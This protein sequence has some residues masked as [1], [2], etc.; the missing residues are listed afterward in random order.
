MDVANFYIGLFKD[1]DDPMTRS[2]L[3]KFLY[4]AQAE[5]MVRLDYLLFE[6]E[7]EARDSGPVI[8][9]INAQF[10]YLEDT[11]PIF[12]TKGDYDIHVFSPEQVEL[13]VDVARCCGRY[14]TAELSRLIRVP[15]G[16]WESAFSDGGKPAII[17]KGSMK[18]F[19]GVRGAVPCY[20]RDAIGRLDTEGCIDENGR[21]VLSEDWE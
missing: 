20:T 6:D 19:Y 10:E 15:G 1:R 11:E 8:S 3:Q 16:P 21:L 4:F 5:S 14:S 9:G 13:L 12:N 2:R 18:S 7:F 17:T